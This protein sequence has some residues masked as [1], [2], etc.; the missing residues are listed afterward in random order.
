MFEYPA[1]NRRT[2]E[3]IIRHIEKSDTDSM[4]GWVCRAYVFW[5]A[6]GVLCV[7]TSY[8]RV[9]VA[10]TLSAV[11]P[12]F[13]FFCFSFSFLACHARGQSLS[14]LEVQMRCAN[15][16]M[17]PRERPQSFSAKPHRLFSRAA[18]GSRFA[19]WLQ[20]TRRVIQ[21]KVH[22]NYKFLPRTTGGC[23]PPP[24]PI[25]Y[26]FCIRLGNGELQ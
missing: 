19:V 25:S 7:R 22:D 12:H 16:R 18:R 11:S 26:A 14:C 5:A 4:C 6:Q 17:Y 8:F 9:L 2:A 10:G 13:F 1:T 21:T 3:K 15:G 20:Y 23:L 24:W